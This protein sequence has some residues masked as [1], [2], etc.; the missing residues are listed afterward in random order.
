MR[1]TSL[2]IE[3][4]MAMTQLLRR[5]SDVSCVISNNASGSTTRQF[6]DKS[7]STKLALQPPQL[8]SDGGRKGQGGRAD[9]TTATAWS[10]AGYEALLLARSAAL[11][12]LAAAL[13]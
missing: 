3:R 5:F 10:R 7:S 2:L 11:Y 13:Q 1:L 4:E 8:M 6:S 9:L 12:S